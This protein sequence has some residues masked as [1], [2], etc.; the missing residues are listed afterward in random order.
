MPHSTGWGRRR[1]ERAP[2]E[3]ALGDVVAGLMREAPF[4]RGVAVGRLAA[5]WEAV[6]G[7]RLAAQTA[8]R[9]LDGGI[10]TVAASTGPWG[11]QARFLADEIRV[12]ANRTLGDD[13]VR[14][15]RV[16]IQPEPRKAL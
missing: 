7:P 13:V 6:V 11:A 16:L 5:D 1:D 14:D 2:R 10:L 4:A 9:Q 15:V 12:Q 8:P 3:T